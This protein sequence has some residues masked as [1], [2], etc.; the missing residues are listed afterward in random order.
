MEAMIVRKVR[1]TRTRSGAVRWARAAA[2]ALF[3]VIAVLV[4]HQAISVRT[5][6]SP[7]ASRAMAAMAMPMDSAE[8]GTHQGAA[9]ATTDAPAGSVATRPV[10][11]ADPVMYGYGK[12]A[13]GGAGVEHCS[14]SSVN[15]LKLTAPP[16]MSY[17]E[18]D[19]APHVAGSERGSSGTAERAP[20][21]LL[22]VLSR[23][24]I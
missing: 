19:A 11:Q 5:S 10:L 14:A 24:R 15:T 21:D 20:P 6:T 22:S 4:H 8:H 18:R 7:D 16:E 13:C 23:L 1:L 9:P 17:A 3:L 2:I 12:M